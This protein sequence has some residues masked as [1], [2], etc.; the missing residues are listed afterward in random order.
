MT[1]LLGQALDPAE[2]HFVQRVVTETL[3]AVHAE[4]PNIPID[5]YCEEGAWT[6]EDCRK[7]FS[8][9]RELG[10]PLRLHADQFH[11]LGGVDLALEFGARSIDHLEAT[12]PATLE[13]IAESGT[14]GVMLPV[15]GFH[16]DGRYANARH[17][18]DC[19][20]KLVLA[21][22]DNPGSSPCC[23]MPFALAL[24]VRKLGLTPQE[25]I[26]SA[27]SRAADLLGAT[28]RGTIRVGARADLLLLRHRDERSLAH[29]LGGNPVICT[30][31][32][33]KVYE[34]EERSRLLA[35]TAAGAPQPN[36]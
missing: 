34:S 18:L 26:E 15:S 30:I 5:A 36:G 14:F 8:R 9:A 7:L 4:F 16:T 3:P 24:A 29:E 23:S 17:F 25:A 6:V 11:S 10:H 1:A 33:G 12:A 20:G 22:N 31:V 21:S 2:P 32:G 28:D 27:T 19:G 13:R 35:L